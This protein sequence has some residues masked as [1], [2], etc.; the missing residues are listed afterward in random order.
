MHLLACA[1]EIHDIPQRSEV[2]NVA[3]RIGLIT[4]EAPLSLSS[5]ARVVLRQTPHVQADFLHYLAYTGWSA[6]NPGEHALLWS[7]RYTVDYLWRQGEV[8]LRDAS[9]SLVEEVVSASQECFAAVSGFKPDKVSYSTKSVRGITNWLRSL[10][11]P[12]INNDLF[13]RRQAC[14]AEL[15]VLAVGFA[16]QEAGVASGND[17]LLSQ[18]RREAICKLCLLDPAYL[19]RL[20]DWAL[21]QY[22]AFLAEG[23]RGGSYGRSLRLLRAPSVELLS[24]RGE[25]DLVGGA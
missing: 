16:A 3:Q 12:A 7:Y 4:E 13:A 10:R 24:A 1:A 23:M 19:D 6:S 20:L 17:V 15:L 25:L 21:P 2:V 9:G 8:A 18:E 5:R 11:P 22:P 14:S